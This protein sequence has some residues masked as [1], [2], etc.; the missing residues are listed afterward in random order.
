MTRLEKINLKISTGIPEFLNLSNI[1]EAIENY[2]KRKRYKLVPGMS[3]D[4]KSI[5]QRKPGSIFTLTMV[6]RHGITV[7]EAIELAKHFDF[8]YIQSGNTTMLLH[9]DYNLNGGAR[10]GNLLEYRATLP[11]EYFYMIMDKNIEPIPKE[12]I[13]ELL[14]KVTKK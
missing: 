14:H 6:G 7:E 12:K 4:P 10:M 3:R 2:N 11:D 1:D 8:Y 13:R 5:Y 9:K